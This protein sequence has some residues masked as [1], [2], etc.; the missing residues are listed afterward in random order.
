MITSVTTEMINRACDIIEFDDLAELEYDADLQNQDIKNQWANIRA[1]YKHHMPKIMETLRD[2]YG[3]D[4]YFMNFDSVMTP[5]EKA[6]WSDIRAYGINLLPQVPVLNYFI[7][8]AN[9][10]HRIGLVMDGAKWHDKAKDAARDA[11]LGAEGWE[12]IRVEGRNA[13]ED[14]YMLDVLMRIHSCVN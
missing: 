14:K 13:F 10:L 6:A 7:D 9:P 4:P 1:A 8:F 12:I 5:I 3:Y 2:G 11:R